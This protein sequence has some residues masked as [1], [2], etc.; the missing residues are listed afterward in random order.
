MKKTILVLMSVLF[1]IS[2]SAS[3]TSLC[4]TGKRMDRRFVKFE[5]L[6]V[7]SEVVINLIPFLTID[8]PSNGVYTVSSVNENSILLELRDFNQSNPKY[9]GWY[10]RE[11]TLI[12]RPATPLETLGGLTLILPADEDQ[13]TSSLPLE[14]V[15][16]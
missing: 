16:G 11:F 1:A 13:P 6:E 12:R 5:S 9:N 10:P 8:I 4:R 15:L 14:C 3:E 2:A 7:G